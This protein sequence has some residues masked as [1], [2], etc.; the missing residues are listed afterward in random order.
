MDNLNVMF[1]RWIIECNIQ[2]MD[3]LNVMFGRWIIECNVQEMD[4]LIK[5]KNTARAKAELRRRHFQV[6]DLF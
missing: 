5:E 6:S 2:E 3:N 1:G 4:N